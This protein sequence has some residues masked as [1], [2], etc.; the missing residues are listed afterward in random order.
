MDYGI[1]KIGSHHKEK[2][3]KCEWEGYRSDLEKAVDTDDEENI[4]DEHWVCP[5]CKTVI[6]E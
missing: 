1:N 6:V 3:T 4:I 5:N 2:C